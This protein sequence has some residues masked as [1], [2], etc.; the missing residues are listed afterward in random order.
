M[1]TDQG[2]EFIIAPTNVWLDLLPAGSMEKFLRSYLWA[3]FPSPEEEQ[4]TVDVLDAARDQQITGF[5]SVLEVSLKRF[6]AS[7]P[8]S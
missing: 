7:R 1:C 6:T 2:N 5:I 4:I 8:A 3:S